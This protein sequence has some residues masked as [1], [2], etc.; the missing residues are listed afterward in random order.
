MSHSS[1]YLY[2]PRPSASLLPVHHPSVC[3]P[4]TCTPPVHHPS[5]CLPATCTPP[6]H[7][8]PACIP[9]TCTPPVH[10]PPVC[11][12]AT[13][14][15]PVHHPP[16]C[17][18]ATSTPPVRLPPCYLYTTCTLPARLPPCYL[19]T[20][21]T[22]PARLHPCYLYTTRPSASLLPVHPPPICLAFTCTPPVHYPPACLPATC[23]PPVR[24]PP[25]TY[26]PNPSLHSH[27]CSLSIA[28]TL[29]F[30]LNA[31]HCLSLQLLSS[32]GPNYNR[33]AAYISLM[34]SCKEIFVTKLA[35]YLQRENLIQALLQRI[36]VRIYAT[37]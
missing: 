22:L 4:A 31:V 7:H 27:Y 28:P 26:H 20:T 33:A 8:P 3:L 13:S 10:H 25:I 29:H 6:V 21:C 17:F 14:T 37:T 15:P 18:L 32:R 23:T 24:L 9:A 2:T 5:V 11:L 35:Q 19:Y 34:H 36:S 12:P 30:T 16:V 1:C